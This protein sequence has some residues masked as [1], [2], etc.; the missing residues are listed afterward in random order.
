M[1]APRNLT[2]VPVVARPSSKRNNWDY[3]YANSKTAA[4]ILW[5]KVKMLLNF[6]D[7]RKE[8]RFHH[9]PL[10]GEWAR[11]P[12]SNG[13][14]ERGGKG[15]REK[16]NEEWDESRELEMKLMTGLGFNFVPIFH[17]PVPHLLIPRSSFPVSRS[18]FLVPRSPFSVLVT[19]GNRA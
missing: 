3:M 8:Y 13:R 11:A 7:S 2:A 17:F 18:P 14:S 16:E 9:Q 5:Q 12:F 4:S 15:V 6:R 1:T 10:F 19:F